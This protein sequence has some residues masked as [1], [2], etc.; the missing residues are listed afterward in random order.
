[1]REGVGGDMG[2]EMIWGRGDWRKDGVLERRW[3]EREE[4]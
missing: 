4:E 2:G 1:M 3:E